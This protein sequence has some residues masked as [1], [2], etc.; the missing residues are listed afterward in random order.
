MAAPGE[1]DHSIRPGKTSA[2]EQHAD[3]RDGWLRAVFETNTV[4]IVYGD[5]AGRL[6]Q[7]NPAFCELLG[8]SRSELIGRS[9]F[10]LTHPDDFDSGHDLLKRGAAGDYSIATF[11]KRYLAKDGSVVWALVTPTLIRAGGRP[12]GFSVVIVDITARRAAEQALAESEA[13][14]RQLQKAESLGVLAGG[15][16]HDFNNLLVGVLSNAET[17]LIDKGDGEEREALTDIIRAAE[18]AAELCQRMM[19]FAGRAPLRRQRT[20]LSQLVEERRSRLSAIVPEGCSLHYDLAPQ[21]PDVLIDQRLA[22]QAL[23][24][25]IINATESCAEG[26]LHIEVATNLR[27]FDRDQLRRNRTH[28][29]L[30]PREYVCLSV[31]DNGS[32]MDQP[33]LAKMFDPFFSTK[34]AG[35]GLGLAALHGVV[36]AHGGGLLVDS[37]AGQGTTLTILFSPCHQAP[38]ETR[39]LADDPNWRGSGRVLLVEDEAMVRDAVEAMLA[40]LGFEVVTAVDGSQALQ[41]YQQAQGDFRCVLLDQEMP[42]MNG[43]NTLGALREAGAMLPV[44]VLS[45]YSPAD[46]RA[47]FGELSF[48][49]ILSKPFRFHDLRRTLRQ[50]LEA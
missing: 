12:S 36:S 7:I 11:E 16:A 50:V 2:G 42:Q 39:V 46:V 37:A 19:A 23:T 30:L 29:E 24:T 27:H 31:S 43:V 22:G 4:G 25:L 38:G 6:H 44:V 26:G 9:F 18:R 40:R 5:L 32:G 14:L 34:F 1:V 28:S 47:A 13:R 15:V 17:L 20:S 49:D 45:G 8:Y 10:E 48:A 33:T 21:L 41:R 3:A 35:R